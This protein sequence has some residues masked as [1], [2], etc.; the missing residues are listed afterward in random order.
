MTNVFV[1]HAIVVG[2]Y[3]HP[4]A[5]T[6]RPSGMGEPIQA[7]HIRP[8][9]HEPR[10]REMFRRKKGLWLKR[11]INHLAQHG[12]QL[13]FVKMLDHGNIMHKTN[14]FFVTFSHDNCEVEQSL[15]GFGLNINIRR[16]RKMSLDK[17][18]SSRLLFKEKHQASSTV[19][20]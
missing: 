14:Q 1:R 18:K 3:F 17:N 12:T 7:R 11:N 20:G 8:F 9:L 4:W 2:L 13:F 5:I 15:V 10:E 16:T 19:S 6:S